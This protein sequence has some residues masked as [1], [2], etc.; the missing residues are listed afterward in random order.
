LSFGTSQIDQIQFTRSTTERK[1]KN[2][3]KKKKMN[4]NTTKRGDTET[5][6]KENRTKT[7]EEDETECVDFLSDRFLAVRHRW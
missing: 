7:A 2:R 1:K 4:N 5:E 3:R 6:S